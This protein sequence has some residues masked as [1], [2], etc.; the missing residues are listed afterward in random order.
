MAQ[1]VIESGRLVIMAVVALTVG[2]L[3]VV[4]GLVLAIV[5]VVVCRRDTDRSP[6]IDLQHFF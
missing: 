5:L 6:N 2:A 3:A 1:I 4:A